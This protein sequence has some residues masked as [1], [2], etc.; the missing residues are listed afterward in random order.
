MLN[1]KIVRTA[2]MTAALSMICFSAMA[3]MTISGTPSP[4]ATVGKEYSF[5]PVV[6]NANAKLLQFAY[7]GRPS[8]AADYRGSGQITGIPTSPGVYPNIQ[9]QAWDGEHFAETAPFTITVLASGTSAPPAQKLE[10]SGTPATS[11]TVGEYYAF[12]PTVVAPSGSTLTY[13]VSNKP[14][15]TQF[16]S[17]TGT[18]TGTPGAANVANDGDIVVTV[19]NGAQSASLAAFNIAVKAAPAAAAG[20]ATLSWNKPA[21]NTNG[22]P[23]T[24]LAGYIVRYGTSTAALNAQIQVASPNTDVEINNLS[25]GTWYFEVASINT[26]NI[27]SQFSAPV[28]KSVN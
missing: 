6:H 2:S 11:A 5:T 12:T 16:S 27:E 7:V 25:A 21:D 14:S 13:S 18:L 22:T 23:L 3:Q 4:T 1:C 15:W 10:I 9:I 26:A 20:S 19:S 24:N 28:S 8:W 17:A